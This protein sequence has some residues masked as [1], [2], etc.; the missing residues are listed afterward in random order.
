M[1][2]FNQSTYYFNIKN[3]IKRKDLINKLDTMLKNYRNEKNIIITKFNDLLEKK[4][5]CFNIFNKNL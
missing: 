4:E 3:Q 2:L 1:E 5:S